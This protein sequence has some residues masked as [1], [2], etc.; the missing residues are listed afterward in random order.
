MKSCLLLISLCCF[1]ILG[2]SVPFNKSAEW[3]LFKAT[4]KKVYRNA[5]EEQMRFRTWFEKTK[6]I[7]EHNQKFAEGKVSYFKRIN[8]F[9][10]MAAQE[11]LQLYSGLKIENPNER[12]KYQKKIFR[13]P[14]GP[15]SDEKDWRKAGAVTE[16][17][18][19]T[20]G[21]TSPCESCYAFSATGAIEAQHFLAT[22]NL[23]SLSEQ[24]I[25]DCSNQGGC[26]RGY[27]RNVFDYIVAEG[28]INSEGDYPYEGE[29]SGMCNYNSDLPAAS[30]GGYFAVDPNEDALKA[31]VDKLGPVSIGM[32]M[33]QSFIEYGGGVYEAPE[34]QNDFA[35]L[36]HAVLIVG[37]G[38]EDMLD[39]WLVKNSF[40]SFANNQIGQNFNFISLPRALT[41]VIKD[42]LK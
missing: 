36:N 38:N 24:Q 1:V 26:S 11:F 18:D 32:Q 16:V 9:S 27:M 10:D 23:V 4:H 17:K 21:K 31:A 29:E 3:K 13:D 20:L 22:R 34:C 41:G 33:L 12:G 37:Y 39:Y 40:V 2:N 25:V 30:I 28:A 8:K 15:T 6:A 5:V 35:S 14:I 7:D 19:Q 42:T